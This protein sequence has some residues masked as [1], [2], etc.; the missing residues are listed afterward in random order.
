MLLRRSHT[1]FC[2]ER[3]WL[4][5]SLSQQRQACVH[6]EEENPFRNLEVLILGTASCNKFAFLC[7]SLFLFTISLLIGDSEKTCVF[8][9]LPCIFGLVRTYRMFSVR[10]GHEHG[11]PNY[12]PYWLNKRLEQN[13]RIFKAHSW[14]K[15][16][17]GPM[18]RWGV[19]GGV[20]FDIAR[21][22]LV[23][24]YSLALGCGDF[25]SHFSE[26]LHCNLDNHT[27]CNCGRYSHC[28]DKNFTQSLTIILWAEFT[29]LRDF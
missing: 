4:L 17:S 23:A 7:S 24:N 25:S 28:M 15:K 20:K 9:W 14:D 5:V 6:S 16:K 1:G 21:S 12:S 8:I 27:R 3:S 22:Y 13:R 2:L 26:S 18:Y 29:R 10:S 19:Q 11:T